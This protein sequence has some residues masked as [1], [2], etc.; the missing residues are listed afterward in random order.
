M[1]IKKSKKL[2][3]KIVGIERAGKMTE[4]Q[5]AA[6]VRQYFLGDKQ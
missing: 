6:K 1:E 5:I 2:A 4:R 3:L